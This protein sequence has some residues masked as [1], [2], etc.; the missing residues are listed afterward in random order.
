[1]KRI[2]CIKERSIGNKLMVGK[3]YF[4]DVCSIYIDSDGDVYAEIY[5]LNNNNFN[6]IARCNLK[7]FKTF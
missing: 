4:M 5:D 7:H 6:F 3:I 1:M 2:I